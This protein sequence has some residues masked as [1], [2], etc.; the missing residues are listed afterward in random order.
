MNLADF[1]NLS[2]LSDRLRYGR[3]ARC[4][5][6]SCPPDR[7]RCPLDADSWNTV[8]DCRIGAPAASITG[9]EPA[10]TA[11]AG[12][13][14][15][16]HSRRYGSPPTTRTD[17][18]LVLYWRPSSVRA[19]GGI[20]NAAHLGGLINQAEHDSAPHVWKFARLNDLRSTQSDS[21]SMVH[22]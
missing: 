3:N 19:A 12:F 2:S 20:D 9:P 21:Q 16:R 8:G 10:A 5:R 4:P 6:P 7:C 17:V 15:A 18:A 13:A 1:I 14:S 11:G 22:S